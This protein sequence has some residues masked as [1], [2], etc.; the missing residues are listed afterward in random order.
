MPNQITSLSEIHKI[1][2]NKLPMSYLSFQL[3]FNIVSITGRIV[4]KLKKIR[5]VK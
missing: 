1:K 3:S 2:E 4:D 5:V